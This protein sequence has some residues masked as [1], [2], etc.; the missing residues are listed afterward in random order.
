MR[1]VGIDIETYDPFLTDKGASWVYGEGEILCTSIYYSD[2][3]EIKV[4]K[5]FDDEVKSLLLDS[6]VTLIG[7]NIQYDI[8]WLETEIGIQNKTKATLVDIFFAESLI[9]EYSSVSLD[10]LSQKYLSIGKKKSKLESWATE[11]GLKG[12]FRK[13]L[14]EA[15]FD[16]LSEYASSDAELPVLIYEKQIKILERENLLEPFNTDCSLIKVV[17]NMKY[18]GARVDVEAKRRNAELL[19]KMLDEKLKKFRLRY[20]KI[21]LASSKQIASL[22]DSEDIPYKIKFTIKNHN[23]EVVSWSNVTRIRDE[24]SCVVKGFRLDKGNL[25]CK[26]DNGY[27]DRIK[28]ILTQNGYSFTFNPTIDSKY[29]QSISDEY[30]IALDIIN[31]KKIE[32]ILSKF[33]GKDFDRFIT[34]NGRVHADFNIS[35][36]DTYGTK[37]GRFSCSMP[38]LQQIPSK[39][40]IDK[41]ADTEVVLS[42]LCREV[43]VPEDGCWLMKIDYSQIEYRLLVHYAF[44]AGSDD[45]RKQFNDDPDTDYHEFVMGITGLDRK[46]AKNCNFGIMYGMG[47]IGMQDAFGWSKEKVACVLE[48]Y[49]SALPYVKSTMDKVQERSKKKGYIVTIGGRKAHLRSDSQAYVMLNRLN[50]GGSADIMKKAML[51]AFDEGLLDRLSIAI[52][53]HDELVGSVPKT[54]DGIE[55]MLRLKKIMESAYTLRVPV[56]AEPELGDNWSNVKSYKEFIDEI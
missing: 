40:E 14:K 4:I 47:S 11:K 2:T 52:T 36:G 55:D 39:G 23:G 25:V 49:H 28:D 24:L 8:G 46:Q 54:K 42:K 48:T 27:S 31:I 33:I 51:Q 19:D 32:G 50:Q 34:K 21:N 20:G 38:N 22:F 29:L 12:D 17:L 30:L 44:G 10:S 53:V 6:D 7:A 9:D 1:V 15:P 13:H 26:I 56:I 3:K 16:L 5:G 18:R 35:K 45:V 37:S 41:G 43:F